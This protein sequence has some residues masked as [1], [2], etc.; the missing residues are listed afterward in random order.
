[1]GY[2]RKSSFTKILQLI[3]VRTSLFAIYLQSYGLL[4]IYLLFIYE[5]VNVQRFTKTLIEF[6]YV[7]LRGVSQNLDYVCLRLVYYIVL[8]LI[9]RGLFAKIW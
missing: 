4:I 3:Y 7:I 5:I 1:M 8:L 2:F 6:V 9:Y